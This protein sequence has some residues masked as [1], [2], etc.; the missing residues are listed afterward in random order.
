MTDRATRYL[1]LFVVGLLLVPAGFVALTPGVDLASAQPAEEFSVTQAEQC[2]TVTPLGDGSQRVEE[3]YDY[4]VQ[5]DYSSYGTSDEQASAT[6]NLYFYRGSD[7]V[8]LVMLHDRRG[9]DV[10]GGTVTFD[11]AGLPAGADWAVED[12]TYEGRDDV[13][14]HDGSRSHIEWVWAPGRNDGAAVRGVGEGYDAITI[15]PG[16]NEQSVRWETW[17]H[18]DESD[19]I[20]T[21]RVLS[22]DGATVRTLDLSQSVTIS[23]GPCAADEPVDPASFELSGLDAPDSVTQGETATV[24]ATVE[25]AGGSA[26]AQSVEFAVDGEVVDSREVGLDAGTSESV[27]FGVDTADLDPGD[28]EV[29]VSTDNDSASTRLTVEEPESDLAPADF[30]LDGLDAPASATQGDTVTVGATVENDGESEG[31][32]PVELRVDGEVVDSREV[33]LAPGASEAV[34]FELATADLDPG[35]HDLVVGT[36]NDSAGTTLTVE[37]PA[38]V[39]DPAFFAV[40]G[41]DAPDS[42]TQGETAAVTATVGNTGEREDTQTVELRIN[43]AIIDSREV[44]LAPGT[45]ETVTLELDASGRPPG[46]YGLAVASDDDITSTVVTIATPESD[47]ANFRLSGLDAPASATQGDTVTVGATVENDGESEG[48]QPVELRVD[49]E[50]VDSREVTLAPGATETVTLGLDT[51]DLDPG[52]HDLVVGTDNDSADATLTVEEPAPEPRADFRLSDL[53]APTEVTAGDDAPVAATVENAGDAEGTQTV[54]LRVGDDVV[55]SRELT[56]PAG[57]RERVTLD[58]GVGDRSPG[59]YVVVLSTDNHSVDRSVA[60]QSASGSGGGSSGG[61]T[62]GGGSSSGGSGGGGGGGGSGAGVSSD[63]ELGVR[64]VVVVDR[65]NATVGTPV[66]VEATVSNT[67]VVPHTRAFPLWVDGETVDE[68]RVNVD[69]GQERTVTFS[70]TFESAGTHE[71]GVGAR[72]TTLDVAPG[73]GATTTDPG[74]T[75]TSAADPG[76]TTTTS[77]GTADGTTTT[78]A[79]AEREPVETADPPTEENQEGVPLSVPENGMPTDQLLGLG[80][81]VFLAIVVVVTLVYERD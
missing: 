17:P 14:E 11:L 48:T 39:L 37:E 12:D 2:T 58:S 25:N 60:V 46:D 23:P 41:L 29:R 6:S 44:E 70:Y 68:K 51:T 72:R 3:Y 38:P 71:L 43:G 7:G 20:T 28:H 61:S 13:F 4:R 24:T 64:D 8:S 78:P 59:E 54:E 5:P 47:P 63:G 10:G 52:D 40:S 69:S 79:T 50:V 55:D 81:A 33:E 77:T 16:F 49:G 53:D 57:E 30:R 9:D 22:G 18:T 45:S 31:T 73:T 75:A 35:D 32:Q 26:G 80:L 34:G 19:R 74:T 67:D 62:G 56:L 65:A 42:V 21:W 36:D 76:T 27:S 15:Q 1:T 66:E